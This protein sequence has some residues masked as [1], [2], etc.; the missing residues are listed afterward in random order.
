VAGTE[1][2]VTPHFLDEVVRQLAVRTAADGEGATGAESARPPRPRGPLPAGTASI[3]AE[4]LG[5]SVFS[6]GNSGAVTAGAVSATSFA[7]DGSGVTNV[8]RPP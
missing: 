8:D 2:V 1:F 3:P 5:A 6:V 7:G 4:G